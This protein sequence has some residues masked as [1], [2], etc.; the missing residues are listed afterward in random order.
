MA[1][2]RTLFE[3][4]PA[5]RS[6]VSRSLLIRSQPRRPLT[7]L[8]QE[9]NRLV[10]QIE[11]LRAG[12]AAEERRLEHALVFH[13]E[14]IQPRVDRLV[15]LRKDLIRAIEPFRRDRRLAAQ[16]KRELRTI[17]TEQLDAVLEGTAD[18]EDDLR[19]LFTDL[20]DISYDEAER[21]QIDAARSAI[22]SMFADAGLDVD[23]SGFDAGMSEED[24]AA[25]SAGVM[26]DL[27]R[28]AAEAEARPGRRKSKR[29]QREEDRQRLVEEA[30]KTTLGAIYRRLAKALHPDLEPDPDARLRKGTLMQE[31]TTAYAARDMHTLLRLELE[32]LHD[33]ARDVRDLTD[34]KLA[35]HNQL[36]KEQ[37]SELKQA[38]AALA[39]HP[40]YQPL[41]RE[42]PFGPCLA[43]AGADETRAL[44][45]MAARLVEGMARV[46][47]PDGINEVR[48]TIRIRRAQRRGRRR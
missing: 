16:D 32:C 14:H 36:L 12:L 23:L 25:R 7:R 26:E 40:K 3:D 44:D 20:H 27:R 13:C 41:W 21:Q 29:E 45:E 24:V 35:A 33:D 34:E 5:A 46:R 17:L 38:R 37:A 15:A 28:Q 8:Q 39:L 22:E 42:G 1:E 47:A 31:V 2:P 11:T 9:F 18:V 4:L 10:K 48:E 43:P 6:T 19:S 30:R